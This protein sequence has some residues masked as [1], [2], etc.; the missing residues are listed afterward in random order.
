VDFEVAQR[1][2]LF[3]SGQTPKRR[4]LRDRAK[5]GTEK[6]SSEYL[7]IRLPNKTLLLCLVLRLMLLLGGFLTGPEGNAM[8]GR[9]GFSLTDGAVLQLSHV[10][11]TVCRAIKR[12]R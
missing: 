11:F 10:D 6:R 8:T 12:R 4:E 9:E 2:L 5:R 7:S 1:N 3:L